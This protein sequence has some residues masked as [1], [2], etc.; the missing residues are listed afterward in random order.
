LFFRRICQKLMIIYYTNN[1]K[2]FFF[3]SIAPFYRMAGPQRPCDPVSTALF[4]QLR[5]RRSFHCI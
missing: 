3:Y 2:L 4:S 5:C 1:S